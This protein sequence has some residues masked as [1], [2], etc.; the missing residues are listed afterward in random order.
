MKFNC[1]PLSES[2]LGFGVPQ[3]LRDDNILIFSE[4]TTLSA[5]A[6]IVPSFQPAA[7]SCQEPAVVILVLNNFE[8]TVYGLIETSLTVRTYTLF[9]VL[10]YTRCTYY[11][12]GALSG[13]SQ[14]TQPNNHGSRCTYWAQALCILH[15]NI[16]APFVTPP[17][18]LQ[19]WRHFDC[20]F[21]LDIHT[22]LP[23]CPSV[24][25]PCATFD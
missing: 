2:V 1:Q 10:Y 24:P 3:A 9:F 12:L 13:D 7:S 17:L 18:C 6:A 5:A 22:R 15:S 4:S 23:V 14:R 21:Q 11:S 8:L 16:R 19:S 20:T 25:S